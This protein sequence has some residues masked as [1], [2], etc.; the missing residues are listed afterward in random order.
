MQTG[1]ILIT[2]IFGALL[3]GIIYPTTCFG[4]NI[5]EEYKMREH[6]SPNGVN[7]KYVVYTPKEIAADEKYPFVVYLH[8]WCKVCVTHERILKESGLRFWH[9]YDQNK[10]IEPTF[11]FAPVGGTEFWHEEH[12]REAVFEIIDGLIQ[13]FPI[14]KKRIYI[15][16][17]SMGGHG[18]WNYLQYRPNFFAAANPQAIGGGEIDANLVKDTPIWATIGDQ[19]RPD[20]VAQLK[21]NIGKIR[22]ANGDDRGALTNV[23]GVNPRFS[24]F[25]ETNHGGAQAKTQQIPEL[26]NWFYA[27]INDGNVPPTIRFVMPQAENTNHSASSNIK[28]SVMAK[29][30]DGTITKVDFFCDGQPKGSVSQSPFEFTFK[31]LSPGMHTLTATAY[32]NGMKK[33][34]ANHTITIK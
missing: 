8:G 30:P 15:L 14:D 10:Q 32:D 28:V 29:D 24:L 1:H 20:R 21:E 23:T 22:L 7:M 18:I 5:P 33:N 27:Q 9:A 13:E 31:N 12:R 25:T 2:I 4:Q 34:S 6:A 16:G 19:D 11:L 3:T 17:F 26:L